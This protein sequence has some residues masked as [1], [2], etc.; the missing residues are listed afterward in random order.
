MAL[1]CSIYIR[2]Y[3]NWDWVYVRWILKTQGVANYCFSELMVRIEPI[4]A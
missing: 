4:V 2:D 1:C 3:W